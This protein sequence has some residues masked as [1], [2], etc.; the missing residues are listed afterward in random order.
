MSD[1]L[2]FYLLG[3]SSTLLFLVTAYA[4]RLAGGIRAIEIRGEE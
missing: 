2:L 4:C 3:V 1:E